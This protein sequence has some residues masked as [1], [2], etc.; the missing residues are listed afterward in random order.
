M[1]EV[2][3]TTPGVWLAL[4]GISFDI[5]V[6]ELFWTLARG[7]TVVVQ[8]PIDRMSPP[9]VERRNPP[10]PAAVPPSRAPTR[11]TSRFGPSSAATE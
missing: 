9:N 4:A 3:G 6:L 8:E 5:S 1:D 11:A 10:H 2:L 7:F